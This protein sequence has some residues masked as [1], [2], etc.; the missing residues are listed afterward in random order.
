MAN[1]DAVSKGSP[2]PEISGPHAAGS[3]DMP[4][5]LCKGCDHNGTYNGLATGKDMSGDCPGSKG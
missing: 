3:K 4:A 2:P 5:E 1:T